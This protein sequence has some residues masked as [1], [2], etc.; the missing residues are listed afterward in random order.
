MIRIFNHYFQRRALLQ[1]VADLGLFAL[2]MLTAAAVQAGGITQLFPAASTHIL[3]L[4]AGMVVIGTAS[5]IYQQSPQ[6]TVVQTFARAA[7][8][9][10][11]VLPLTYL[12][13]GFLSSGIAERQ[14]IQLAGVLGVGAV[15]LR[16]AYLLHWGAQPRASS[17][18]LVFGSGMAARVVGET[19][20]HAD[21]QVELV[22]YLGGPNERE[23]AVPASELLPTERSLIETATAL[24]VDEIVVALTERR[25]GSMPLRQL[26]DCKL[27]GIKV[28]DLAAHFEKRLG[29]I[30]IDFVNAGWLIFGDG[31]NQGALRGA[32]KRVSD[33]ALGAVLIAVA[34]PVMLV[35]SFAFEHDQW[36]ILT[37]ASMLQWSGIFYTS[38]ASSLI[39]HAGIYY[40]LQRYEVSQTAPLTLLSPIFTVMFSVALL[41]DV[42]TARMIVGALIALSGVLIISIRQKRIVPVVS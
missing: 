2:V 11:F 1:A 29:Q 15:V 7:V 8:M 25:A 39:G 41:G 6:T 14:A 18:V 23:V 24:G 33:I 21:P 19:L 42:L 12:A 20:R 32:I 40:L 34:A 36:R 35:G 28:Y 26:L 13:T 37:S 17:R 5:G 38:F 10:L 9:L 27:Q 4:A 31:F 30:R 16:R 3:S 22:G